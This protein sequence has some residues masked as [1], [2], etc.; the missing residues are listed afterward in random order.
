MQH[1][2]GKKNESPMPNG[3]S[4]QTQEEQKLTDFTELSRNAL[5]DICDTEKI[6][7]VKQKRFILQAVEAKVFSEQDNKKNIKQR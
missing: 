6:A 3:V 5:R 7:E 4:S 2:S 1:S